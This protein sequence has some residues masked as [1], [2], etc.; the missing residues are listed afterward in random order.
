VKLIEINIVRAQPLKTLLQSK[1]N[2]ISGKIDSNFPVIEIS[3]YLCCYD[4]AF[5]DIGQS[6]AKEFLT[7]AP[8]VYVCGIIEV[9]P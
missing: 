4:A 7:I 6:L 9:A 1:L 5:S 2:V 8:T 3:P